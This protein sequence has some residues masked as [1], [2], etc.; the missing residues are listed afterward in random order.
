MDDIS[1]MPGHWFLARMGKK[2]LRP[3]GKELT[4]MMM[5][6]IHI[7]TEDDV[8]EF[9]PGLG[10]TT[11][12]ILERNPKSYTG[13]DRDDQIIKQL[14]KL[15]GEQLNCQCIQADIG[16]SGLESESKDVILGEAV[17]TMQSDDK[18]GHIMQEAFR[19]LRSGGRYAIHEIGLAPDDMDN[20]LKDEIRESVSREIRVGA[21]PLTTSEWRGLLENTG[22]RIEHVLMNPFVLL[23]LSRML[24]DEGVFRCLKIVWNILTTKHS[25]KRFRGMRQVFTKYQSQ[26]RAISII[27]KKG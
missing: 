7:T 15:I 27:A 4:N 5:D 3:G 16:E 26:L 8:L 13:V 25:I 10:V 12:L 23:S 19:L 22:F 11:R 24:A 14:R 6:K 20:S 18:K 1:K 9:A 17:L 21:R 2:V